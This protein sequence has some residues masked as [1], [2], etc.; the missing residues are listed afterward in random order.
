MLSF[1]KIRKKSPDISHAGPG[2]HILNIFWIDEVEAVL[3][4]WYIGSESG[5]VIA[6]VLSGDT[7]PSGKLP[8]TSEVFLAASCE[9]A[10]GVPQGQ[11]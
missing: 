9:G 1:P 8:F 3:Q 7:N 2:R 10:Q 11:P 6:D 5:H 4:A